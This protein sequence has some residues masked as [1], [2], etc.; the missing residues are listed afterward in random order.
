MLK[1]ADSA[2]LFAK[3]LSTPG[4]HFGSATIFTTNPELCR[5]V[6]TCLL[7]LLLCTIDLAWFHID[8]M[9]FIVIRGH[10]M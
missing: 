5:A 10:A 7:L 8:I 1:I 9:K 2:S 6:Q 3:P 4:I